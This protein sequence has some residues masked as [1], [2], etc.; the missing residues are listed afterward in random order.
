MFEAYCIGAK[1]LESVTNV[2]KER[3][4]IDSYCIGAK[5]LES[6][7]NVFKECEK[8]NSGKG[9]HIQA[10][11]LSSTFKANSP[12]VKL[13]SLPINHPCS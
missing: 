5:R 1:R 6:V 9:N 7:T 10:N 12:V 3:E 11:V 13:L 2:F 4:K 8:I